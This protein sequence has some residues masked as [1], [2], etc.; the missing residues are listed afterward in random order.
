M[1]KGANGVSPKLR[2]LIMDK[3][4]L[5][6]ALQTS[7]DLHL[8]KIDTREDEVNDETIYSFVIFILKHLCRP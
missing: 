2:A 8:L 7:H 6:N 5:Q 1:Q 3:D 4:A